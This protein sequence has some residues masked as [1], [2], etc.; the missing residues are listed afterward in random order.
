MK[1]TILYIASILVLLL[2]IIAGF[3]YIS[4]QKQYENNSLDAIPIN[5]EFIFKFHSVNNLHSA[6]EGGKGMFKDL[7]ETKICSDLNKLFIN[8]EKYLEQNNIEIDTDKELTCATKLVGKANVDLLYIVE[9]DNHKELK[10]MKNFVDIY[11]SKFIKSTKTYSGEKI[12]IF[13]QN[14]NK[15]HIAYVNGLMLISKSV[16][17]LE[18]A[19]RQTKA[20][21]KLLTLSSFV[22]VQKTMDKNADINIFINNSNSSKIVKLW[23]ERKYFSFLTRIDNWGDWTGLDVDID[24]DGFSLNGFT[25]SSNNKFELFDVLSNQ[26]S[27]ETTLLDAIP[28]GVASFSILSLSNTSKYRDDMIKYRGKRGRLNI[29]RKGL[30]ELNKKFGCKFED[31]FY[32][33][34]SG[35]TALMS[36]S[37]NSINVNANKIAIFKSIGEGK[38]TTVMMEMLNRIA[39]NNKR[40]LDYYSTKVKIDREL[41]YKVYRLPYGDI[42]YRIM[43]NLFYESPS[44]YFVIVNNNLVFGGSVKVL[45]EYLHAINLNKSV[46][47]DSRFKESHKRFSDKGN[48]MFYANTVSSFSQIKHYFNT[49]RQKEI[50]KNKDYFNKFHSVGYQLASANSMVYNNLFVLY[51]DNIVQKPQTEWESGLDANVAIKPAL[52]KNHKTNETEIFVQDEANNVYLINSLGRILWKQPIDG[53]INSEI[54]QVDKYKNKKLQYM[55]STRKKIYLIDRNGNNIGRFPV[56]LKSPTTHGMTVFDYDKNRKYR[57]FVP[58]VNK[59]IYL[60]DIEGNIVKG[61]RFNK[62]ENPITS[63]INHYRVGKKDY[64]VFKDKFKVYILDRRGNKRAKTS[65]YL[66]LSD[67]ELVLVNKKSPYLLLTDKSA[68]IYKVSFSGKITKVRSYKNISSQHLF[69]SADMDNDG[70]QEYIYADNNSL[71]VYS[72]DKKIIDVKVNGQIKSTP[73]IYTFSSTKKMIGFVDNDNY[74]AYLINKRGK[75]YSGFPVSANNPFSITFMRGKN[76]GFYMFVGSRD[77]GLYKYRVQ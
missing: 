64:I 50:N 33:F 58:S 2:I 42:P 10:S 48:F 36:M 16:I 5:S 18:D 77:K 41:S 14:E 47:D 46:T 31:K 13:S 19:I 49:N 20:K 76:I 4:D 62:S 53:R 7:K 69:T 71:T 38:L 26:N 61:W 6:L 25:S 27:V 8:I 40:S 24:K 34:F 51:S 28:S 57:I 15:Y 35:E 22:E 63:K 44:R 37:I 43:G 32:S 11:F 52:V 23:G 12:M 39:S 55:F 73:S 70:S 54:Y 65:K 29:Y 67:N 3:L 30:I 72:G 21:N 74:K 60:Y 45:T 17:F 66:K 68:T 9:L 59:K 1:K 75:N 56:L